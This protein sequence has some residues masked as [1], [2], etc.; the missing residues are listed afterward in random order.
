MAVCCSFTPLRTPSAA[1]PSRLAKS[2][3]ATLLSL[4]L[5]PKLEDLQGQNPLACSKR[6]RLARMRIQSGSSRRFALRC[7]NETQHVHSVTLRRPLWPF[8]YCGEDMLASQTFGCGRQLV[9]D[10]CLRSVCCL[11][12]FIFAR[13]RPARFVIPPNS[14]GSTLLDHSVT[15][16]RIRLLHK[17]LAAEDNLSWINAFDQYAACAVLFS[18]ALDLPVL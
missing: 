13:F 5:R 6:N 14:I 16:E 12:C 11:R 7:S 15:V 1:V 4:S 18:R 2:V 3:I 17:L 8:R 9:L 10:Q